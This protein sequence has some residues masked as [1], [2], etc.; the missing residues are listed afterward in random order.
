MFALRRLA[1]GLD[2]RAVCLSRRSRASGSP[3]RAEVYNAPSRPSSC[4]VSLSFAQCLLGRHVGQARP[5]SI[6]LSSSGDEY[7]DPALDVFQ[8]RV[9]I[10]EPLVVAL[11]LEDRWADYL[12]IHFALALSSGAQDFLKS[13]AGTLSKTWV[14]RAPDLFS[15]AIL[16]NQAT[17][18]L[19]VRAPIL[20]LTSPAQLTRAELWVCVLL[21]RELNTTS[22]G[23]ELSISPS[24]LKA[25][26]RSVYPVR[27]SS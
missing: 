26:L 9:R 4:K 7:A 24:T 11:A 10:V 15:D 6:W 3:A 14:R 5:A 21:S 22:V 19:S 16:T 23:S 25:H 20:D 8:K 2:A 13:L 17:T 27:R 1:E 12:E 18:R